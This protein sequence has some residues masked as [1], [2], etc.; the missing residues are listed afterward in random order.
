M[1]KV[2]EFIK[3]IENATEEMKKLDFILKDFSDPREREKEIIKQRRRQQ[4]KK[5]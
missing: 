3:T 1:N 4:F 5:H 2:E